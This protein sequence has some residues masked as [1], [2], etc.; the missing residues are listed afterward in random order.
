MARSYTFRLTAEGVRELEAQFKAA[1]AA[2]DKLFTELQAKVPGLGGVLE[3]QNKKLDET[4]K[5]LEDAGKGA[6]GFGTAITGATR[7]LGAFGVALEAGHFLLAGSF[8]RP[9]AVKQG[10]TIHVDYGPLGAIGVHFG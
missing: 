7:I 5:R 8:T 2:G 10:D 4:R 6:D 3:T 1:G 9:V